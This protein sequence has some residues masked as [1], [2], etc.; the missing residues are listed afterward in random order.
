[1]KKSAV[2]YLKLSL[3]VLLEIA[4][5]RS[6]RR[7]LGSH[8]GCYAFLAAKKNWAGNDILFVI[9]SPALTTNRVD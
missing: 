8:D 6:Q 7:G 2:L 5:L 9:V 3:S 4:S 1:V